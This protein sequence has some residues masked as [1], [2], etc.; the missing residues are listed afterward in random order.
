VAR[1]AHEGE[2]NVIGDFS[3]RLLAARWSEK[4]I[5]NLLNLLRRP[6]KHLSLEQRLANAKALWAE[7]IALPKVSP[8]PPSPPQRPHL[9]ETRR[10]RLGLQPD[11]D[12]KELAMRVLF[13]E[14]LQDHESVFVARLVEPDVVT[15]FIGEEQR[16]KG[17]SPSTAAAVKRDKIAEA[18]FFYRAVRPRAKH[19]EEVL[20][21]I[22]KQLGVSI[23]LVDKAQRKTAPARRRELEAAAAAFVEGLAEVQ[24]LDRLGLM[25]EKLAEAYADRAYD[26]GWVTD[27]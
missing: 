22:A 2:Q 8:P 6:I 11:I 24:R 10:M 26:K 27:R 12:R 23:S 14:P 3:R 4:R 5:Q 20:P 13:G 19:K 21:E 25:N 9:S 18:Y 17:R 7:L 15:L 1:T 16:K